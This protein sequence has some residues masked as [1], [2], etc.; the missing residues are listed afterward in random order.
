MTTALVLGANSEICQHLNQRLA[1]AGYN[2]ILVGRNLPDLERQAADLK[3][4]GSHSVILKTL[5][6]LDFES[7]AAFID[8]I[9]EE[10]SVLIVA[11]GTLGDLKETE[12]SPYEVHRI[13]ATNYNAALS[14][15]HRVSRIFK[16][17]R[18]G[19]IVALSSVAGDRGRQ[20]NYL[21]GS[22]KA[23]LSIYLQGLR[24]ELHDFGVRVLTVKPGFVRT[25]M[26]AGLSFPDVLAGRP[27]RVASAIYR[28]MQGKTDILYTPFHFRL[29][30]FILNLIP[31]F[32]FKKLKL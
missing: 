10:Y 2:L 22:A 20:S 28:A 1:E 17:K 6:V 30:L 5:D 15:I 21:Y 9:E 23:G 24:Q 31:E 8:G 19:L 29:I 25:R 13:I 26:T 12:T 16:Q 27:E 11:F 18:N 14:L 4:R 32:L 3:V 7:H